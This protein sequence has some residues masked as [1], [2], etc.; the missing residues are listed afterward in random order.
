MK[1]SILCNYYLYFSKY[2][3]IHKNTR[4]FPAF[5]HK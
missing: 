5:F 2:A 4:L 3:I 1:Y